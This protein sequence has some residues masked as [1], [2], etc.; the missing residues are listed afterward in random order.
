[1]IL[2]K[3]LTMRNGER[4]REQTTGILWVI[5]DAWKVIV[6]YNAIIIEPVTVKGYKKLQIVQYGFKISKFVHRLVASCFL[7]PP[8]DSDYQL[9][10]K[11]RK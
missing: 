9:H 7:E 2:L 1:M 3:I 11:D 4:L 8:K 10:H 6:G 5:A